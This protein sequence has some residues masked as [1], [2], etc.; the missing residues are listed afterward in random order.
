[1]IVR[2]CKVRRIWWVRQQFPV[3]A[4]QFLFDDLGH[5]WSSVVVLEKTLSL[6]RPFSTSLAA[7]LLSLARYL[8]A[9]IVHFSGSSSKYTTPVNFHQTQSIRLFWVQAG[10][11]RHCSCLP[12][13]EPLPPTCDVNVEDQLFIA[14]N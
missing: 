4:L 11:R 6:P 8:V 9:F 10:L 14:S 1:M 5:M 2:R 12:R 3:V 7:I 13:K